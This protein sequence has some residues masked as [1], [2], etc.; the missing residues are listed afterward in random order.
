MQKEETLC[1]GMMR[2]HSDTT[3]Y[4]DLQPPLIHNRKF[5]MI[6]EIDTIAERTPQQAG[7][8]IQQLII[9]VLFG[10]EI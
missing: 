10:V 7:I 4:F 1:S 3:I 8:Y 9:T 5:S 2:S 6:A